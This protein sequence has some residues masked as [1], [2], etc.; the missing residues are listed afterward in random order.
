MKKILLASVLL[1]E[2]LLASSLK[3]GVVG[4]DM[5]YKEYVNGSVLDSEETSLS[6]LKGM[7][8]AYSD[9]IN[10][11]MS[12]EI[13]G[14]YILG[15]SKY[16]GA[17]INSNAGYGSFTSSTANTFVDFGAT[18]KATKSISKET[19]LYLGI[20]VGRKDWQRDLSTTYTETY[21]WIY[22]AVS[23]GAN[24]EI[25]SAFDIGLDFTYKYALD[26]N[27]HSSL[28]GHSYTLG[29]ATSY[30]FGIP[31][32]YKYSD[33]YEFFV[34]NVIEVQDIKKSDSRTGIQEP[35]STTNN[36]YLKLGL[37]YNF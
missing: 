26:P 19:E 35:D 16:V 9:E 21:S 32:V 27:M 5:D 17:L 30:A 8:I 4:V 28:T 18:L 22:T 12:Y 13:Y 31:I 24:Y 10:E 6:D 1:S 14:S 7:E 11:L 3:I 20:G 33:T 37:V 2:L 34:E 15:D 25:N 36:Y 23:A 29:G